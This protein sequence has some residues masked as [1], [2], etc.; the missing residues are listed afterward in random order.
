M[1]N[2]ND[3]IDLLF[4][5]N[6]FNNLNTSS[7]SSAYENLTNW[8]NGFFQQQTTSNN[9]IPDYFSNDSMNYFHSPSTIDSSS[10]STGDSTMVG[11][12]SMDASSNA[13]NALTFF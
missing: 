13:S 4:N 10:L 8:Q 6:P 3:E 2:L 1:N 11:N 7:S 12:T 5:E 9:L